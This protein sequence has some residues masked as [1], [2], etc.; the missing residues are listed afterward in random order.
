MTDLI[1]RPSP[2]AVAE[3]VSPRRRLTTVIVTWNTVGLLD[4]CLASVVAATPADTDNEIIVVDNAS[5][6]GSAEHLRRAWPDVT[7]LENAEN[8]GFCRANNQ[9]IALA[10]A[11]ELLLI[12]TDARLAPDG[13]VA[14]RAHLDR[15][16]LAAVVGPRLVYADGSWQR[17]TA[18]QDVTLRTL[19][20]YLL[21]LD[22]LGRIGGDPSRHRTAGIYLGIDTPEPFRPG[23]VSSAVMMVRR[24]ALDQVGAFDDDI[25]VYMDD[26]DLCQR[27]TAA[28]WHVW[29]AADTTAVHF[30]GSS[31][32]Q[33]TGRASP[34]ALRALNRWYARRAGA[35]AGLALRVM[36]VVGFGGRAAVH[37]VRAA[38]ARARPD[39]D[40]PDRAAALRTRAAD[41]AR[42]LRLALEPIRVDRSR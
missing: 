16:P 17:W 8:V 23:W 26:V 24:V 32:R 33:V 7:V 25:F 37:T 19:A 20:C 38:V 29:Y 3:Q 35:T 5:G 41:H 4:D 10:E 6:D 28:G 21:G 2:T 11:P 13:I 15:D 40:R 27:V 14:M 31:S 36:E 30:M 22:R 18:G 39:P 42:L 12:N 34:E 9:A 1:T